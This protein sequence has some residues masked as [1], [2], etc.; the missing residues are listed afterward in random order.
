MWQNT[1]LTSFSF[2]L[3]LFSFIFHS[4]FFFLFLV[5]STPER[6]NVEMKGWQFIYCWNGQGIFKAFKAFFFSFRLKHFG[7]RSVCHRTLKHYEPICT[8]YESRNFNR[9]NQ[10][11]HHWQKLFCSLLRSFSLFLL[12][13]GRVHIKQWGMRI[14]RARRWSILFPV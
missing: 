13:Q 9:F 5:Q 3:L 14:R 11:I 12:W 6:R 2:S 8:Q 4:F 1:F 7:S 10:T